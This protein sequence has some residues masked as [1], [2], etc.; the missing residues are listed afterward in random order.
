VPHVII[1]IKIGGNWRISMGGDPLPII[2]NMILYNL[3]NLDEQI[4]L[5]LI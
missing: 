5:K 2:I 4:K 3:V 1:L